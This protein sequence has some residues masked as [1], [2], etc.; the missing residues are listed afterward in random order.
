MTLGLPLAR[1][2]EG[3][4]SD[5]DEEVTAQARF[6]NKSG[7]EGVDA[8]LCLQVTV[9]RGSQSWVVVCVTAQ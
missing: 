7:K 3:R 4:G 5:H 8:K 2:K 9:G 1:D 6:I